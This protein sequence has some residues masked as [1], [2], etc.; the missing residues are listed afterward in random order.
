MSPVT[1]SAKEQL[2]AGP[3]RR[4]ILACKSIVFIFAWLQCLYLTDLGT[5]LA[6]KSQLR[7]LLERA[8]FSATMSGLYWIPWTFQCRF[9]C[10]LGLVAC[11]GTNSV[12]IR[13]A[14]SIACYWIPVMIIMLGM[15]V[16]HVLLQCAY[17]LNLLS[18]CWAWDATHMTK[19][20][21]VS[22]TSSLDNYSC[23]I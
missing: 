2:V 15:C 13:A 19:F 14:D 22:I 6:C 7:L 3:L 16:C 18:K 8:D 21:F 17:H 11:Y 5:R 23:D 9:N 4:T 12:C 1:P 20:Y 10:W